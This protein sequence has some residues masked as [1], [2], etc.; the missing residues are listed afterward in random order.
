M[1]DTQLINAFEDCVNRMAAGQ[2]VEECIAL[3]PDLALTLR[4]MLEAGLLAKRAQFAQ[5]EVDQ[6]R[7]RVRSRL[8]ASLDA[9]P[10]RR[11]NIIRPAFYTLATAAA[12]VVLIFLGLLPFAETSLPGDPLY[13]VKRL[14]E[15]VQ[16]ALPSN[17]ELKSSLEQRRVDE[18][19][20]LLTLKR[21]AEVTFRGRVEVVTADNWIVAGLPLMLGQELT[22]DNIP[23]GTK[24]EVVANTTEKGELI[25]LAIAPLPDD[26]DNQTTPIVTPSQIPSSTFT[27]APTNTQPAP[28]AT[29]AA[30]TQQPA[31]SSDDMSEDDDSDGSSDDSE[32]DGESGEDD[33]PQATSTPR[34]PRQPTG[35]PAST[36]AP[37]TTPTLALVSSRDGCSGDAPDGW[38]S[39]TVERGDTLSGLAAG[40]GESIDNL[41]DGNCMESSTLRVGQQIFLPDEPVEIEDDPQVIQEDEAFEDDDPLLEEEDEFFDDDP[42][43]AEEDFEG[44]D[45]AVQEAEDEDSGDDDSGSDDDGEDDSGDADD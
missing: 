20:Q 22:L 9:V 6:A 28:T 29:T 35:T 37:N 21:P 2:T 8:E 34:P 3:Y 40:T 16:V 32:D 7:E 24:V 33:Q 15:D 27:P 11:T 39:Y 44:D 43:P 1:V 30:P 26:G 23:V 13:A 19:K 41:M 12:A 5:A 45:D 4:P 14:G 31:A 18:V 38:I 17:Q 25:A 10:P 36:L 42:T